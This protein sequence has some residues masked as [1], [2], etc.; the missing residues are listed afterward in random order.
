MKKFLLL[1]AV[2][3]LAFG[4]TACRDEEDTKDEL[5]CE[6]TP[7]HEDCEVPDPNE[8]ATS[9]EIALITDVGTIDDGSF[10]QGAWEGVVRY[11]Y[12]NGITHKYYQ[13]TAKTTDDYVAAIELA[14]SEG[15]TTVVCPGFLFENAV[16]VVQGDHPTVNFIILD[17]APHNVTDWDTMDTVDG[18]APDFTVESN[19]RPI[20]YA[21]HESG[22]LAGYAAVADGYTELGFVGGMAVPA[23]VRFGYGY[24]QGANQAAIDM[25]LADGAITV[26]YWYS[27]VFWETSEVQ[28]TAVAW[29]STGT[30][31]IF[32]AAGGAGQSVFEAGFQEGGLAIGVDIDQEDEDGIVITSAM[33]EL[34]NSVNDTLAEIYAETFTGGEAVTFDATNMG[35]ALPQDFSR[36][37]DFDQAAYDE[38]YAKLV[39]GTFV[40]DG[41]NEQTLAALAGTL[42]KLTVNDE[43]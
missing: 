9:F 25:G 1:L 21:E 23:V 14:I 11:A 32:A 19:T 36:F 29:Y 39:D 18:S 5:D 40:V 33:K 20:F 34:A 27:N 38:L 24:L 13:P 28:A 8:G 41:N 15:A 43:N 35:V 31:V 2:F 12:N 17:G 22:F 7:D 4:L 10:N 6:V 3:S 30:E 16:W 42:A 26:N 37:N